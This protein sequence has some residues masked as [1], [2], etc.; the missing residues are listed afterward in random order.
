MLLSLKCFAKLSKHVASNMADH[1][2]STAA[3]RDDPKP[4]TFLARVE[5]A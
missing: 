1:P 2:E 5:I 3:L 4:Y